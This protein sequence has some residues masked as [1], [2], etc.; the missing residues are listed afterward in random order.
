[1]KLDAV[2]SDKAQQP[3]ASMRVLQLSS[4]PKQ[5]LFTVGPAA[6]YLGMSADTLRKYADLKCIPTYRNPFNGHRV[7]KLEDL[8]HLIDTLPPWDDRTRDTAR[9]GRV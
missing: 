3:S 7:F 1:M 6:R 5:R 4:V 9:A 2:L 8:N